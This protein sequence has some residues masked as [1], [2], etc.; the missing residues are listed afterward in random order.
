M[1]ILDLCLR[2]THIIFV[3]PSFSKSSVFK[4]FSVHTETKSRCLQFPPIWRAFWKVPFSWRISVD[5]RPNRRNKAAFSNFSGA[6]WTL[7][8]FWTNSVYNRL[9][10]CL[11]CGHCL[12]SLGSGPWWTEWNGAAKGCSDSRIW[13]QSGEF[14]LCVSYDHQYSCM[15]LHSSKFQKSQWPRG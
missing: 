6:V 15:S 1:V 10:F 12:F 7:L 9:S 13:R 4:M 14:V 3:T 5:R 8:K 2:K 11:S